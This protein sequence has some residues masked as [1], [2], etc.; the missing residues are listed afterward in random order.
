MIAALYLIIPSLFT[1][2]AFIG[3]FVGVTPRVGA[4]TLDRV[5]AVTR[6]LAAARPLPDQRKGPV[7]V[8]N[9]SGWSADVLRERR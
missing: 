9:H 7:G 5:E 3:L 8:R 1:I 4:A 2:L 6:R